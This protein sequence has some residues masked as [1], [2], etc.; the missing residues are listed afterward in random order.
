MILYPIRPK[1]Y[2]WQCNGKATPFSTSPEDNTAGFNTWPSESCVVS[3]GPRKVAR[4]QWAQAVSGANPG[5]RKRKQGR[6]NCYARGRVIAS[7]SCRGEQWPLKGLRATGAGQRTVWPGLE[8]APLM[9]T[10]NFELP[11]N[12]MMCLTVRFDIGVRF[13]WTDGTKI[14][15]I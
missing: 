4:E 15:L 11:H 14:R 8:D 7:L 1:Q 5:P 3:Q 2:N 9:M 10:L 6:V 12:P 13:I